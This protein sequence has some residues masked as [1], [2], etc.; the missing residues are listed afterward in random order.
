MK[1]TKVI[2]GSNIVV[3]DT[4]ASIWKL[5]YKGKGARLTDRYS[6]APD[7][8]QSKGSTCC[9]FLTESKFP[10]ELNPDQWSR[11]KKF[12]FINSEIGYFAAQYDVL[13]NAPGQVDVYIAGGEITY[14]YDEWYAYLRTFRN[15]HLPK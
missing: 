1:V 10:V 9:I 4:I 5:E 14:R 11:F 2:R 12:A 6:N 8:W 15:I 7:L 3:G 13:T